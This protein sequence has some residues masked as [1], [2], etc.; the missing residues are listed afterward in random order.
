L[1]VGRL[2]GVVH[3][4]EEVLV[5]FHDVSHGLNVHDLTKKIILI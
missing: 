2:E 1:K 3:D 4:Q 5:L